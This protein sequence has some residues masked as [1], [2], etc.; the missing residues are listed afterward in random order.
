MILSLPTLPAV[1][2]VTQVMLNV[3]LPVFLIRF[4][5]IHPEIS[6]NKSFKLAEWIKL[7]Q[8]RGI[9]HIIT[10]GG[11]YSNHLLA[12]ASACEVLGWK[13]TGIVRGAD[14]LHQTPTL[15]RCSNMGMHLLRVDATTYRHWQANT[16]LIPDAADAIIIPEGGYHPLGA[17]GAQSMTSWIPDS[18]THI[19]VAAGTLTTLA[20][21]WT[22]AK[23]HQTVMGIPVLKGMNDHRERLSYLL[24][25]QRP[26]ARFV[27]MDG[28]H[29]G[30][31]AKYTPELLQSM[32]RLYE[33]HSVKTDFVY[34]GKLWYALT[35]LAEQQYFPPDAQIAF[36][37]SGG[38]LGNAGLPAGTLEF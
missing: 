1:D 34:T 4:D 19:L 5:R 24:G 20:G 3:K 10:F 31:Y 21:I 6:G 2:R 14:P 11:P 9:Q 18:C 8:A 16:D 27:W 29:Q 33:Q 30:G 36:V 17:Q 13:A 32:N 28:F 22:S 7:G 15:Q 12:T 23:P 37:H 38:L 35:Q 26:A 25:D